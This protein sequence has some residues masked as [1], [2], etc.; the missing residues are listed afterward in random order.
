MPPS[1]FIDTLKPYRVQRHSAAS[2]EL[3]QGP[4]GYGAELLTALRWLAS[5]AAAGILT[6]LA[7][8]DVIAFVTATLEV[9]KPEWKYEKLTEPGAAFVADRYRRAKEDPVYQQGLKS[10][11]GDADLSELGTVMQQR[12]AK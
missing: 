6:S 12:L 10:R 3:V 2:Y 1:P 9:D 7:C 8:E 5:V 11:R 4:E